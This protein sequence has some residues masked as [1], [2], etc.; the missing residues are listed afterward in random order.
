M[1]RYNSSLNVDQYYFSNPFASEDEFLEFYR[2]LPTTDGWTVSHI[3][4]VTRHGTD[5]QEIHEC[6]II[7]KGSTQVVLSIDPL[8]NNSLLAKFDW[9]H[10]YAPLR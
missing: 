7:N 10:I 4:F 9:S 3:G 1:I 5:C 2:N 8:S 6:V